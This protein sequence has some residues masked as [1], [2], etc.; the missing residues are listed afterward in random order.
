MGRA[1]SASRVA[2]VRIAVVAPMDV[3]GTDP[4]TN[5]RR[6]RPDPATASEIQPASRMRQTRD[7]HSCMCLIDDLREYPFAEEVCLSFTTCRLIRDIEP[8]FHN[9][10][11]PDTRAFHSGT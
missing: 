11:A 4:A 8:H 3:I 10:H 6:E 5:H 2:V 7:W 1:M 9:S